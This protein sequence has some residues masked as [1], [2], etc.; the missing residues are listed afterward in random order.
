MSAR[1]D[2]GSAAVVSLATKRA[3]PKAARRDLSNDPRP[4]VRLA[5]GEIGRIVDQTEAALMKAECGLYQRDN[6]IVV[7]RCVPVA[8]AG[9]DGKETSIQRIFERGDQ[10]L[11]EDMTKSAY[12]VKIRGGVGVPPEVVRHCQRPDAAH[13]RLNSRH[14]GLQRPHVAAFDPRGAEFP[15]IPERPTRD[16]ALAAYAMLVR[17]AAR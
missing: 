12:F 16:D 17:R 2:N 11:L 5:A 8:A 15:P 7:V 9:L 10:A 4:T 6:K 13:G 14:A 3:R 1:D